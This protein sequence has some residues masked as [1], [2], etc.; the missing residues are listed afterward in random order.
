MV[1]CS[2]LLAI[3]SA[4]KLGLRDKEWVPMNSIVVKKTIKKVPL[5]ERLTNIQSKLINVGWCH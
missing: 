1:A 4:Q 5:E 3:H 2:T